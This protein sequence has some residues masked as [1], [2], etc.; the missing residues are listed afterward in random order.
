MTPLLMILFQVVKLLRILFKLIPAMISIVTWIN[1]VVHNATDFHYMSMLSSLKFN[2]NLKIE[3]ILEKTILISNSNSKMS[4]WIRLILWD[5]MCWMKH[6]FKICEYITVKPIFKQQ[7]SKHLWEGYDNQKRTTS[8][9]FV[10]ILSFFLV[11]TQIVGK[12]ISFIFTTFWQEIGLG[13][14]SSH[15]Q[16]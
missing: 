16:R 6:I 2:M 5:T 12:L 13:R 8:D 11:K 3:H 14:L 10:K 7:M 9:K 4:K 1:F 15:L